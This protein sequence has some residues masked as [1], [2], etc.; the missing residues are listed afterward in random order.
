MCVWPR[1]SFSRSFRY[2]GKRVLRIPATPHMVALG[3]A[4]GI[5]SAFTPLYGFHVIFSIFVA[6]TMSANIAA[7]VIGTAFA[8]PL[9]IPFIFSATYELG[10]IFLPTRRAS[11]SIYAFLE[12]LHERIFE[13]LLQ[14]FLQL[15]IGSFILGGA[16]ALIVYIL[17]LKATTHFRIR[18]SEWIARAKGKSVSGSGEWWKEKL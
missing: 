6:W 12:L 18:R 16:A 8:N 7:A 15:I 14:V 13:Q 4:I 9:T 3:L 1:R 11:L 10:Y 17:A 2:I 5:F